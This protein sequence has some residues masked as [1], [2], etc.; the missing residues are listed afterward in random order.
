[1]ILVSGKVCFRQ[2]DLERVRPAMAAMVNASLGEDGCIDYAYSI[3]VLDPTVMRI[4]ERW[5]DRAALAAHF[6]TPHMAQ[7][8]AVLAELDISD[9]ELF[10]M[11]GD[12]LE[13]G[14]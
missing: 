8:L 14:V 7:W 1:M 6:Q 12:Q 4:I 5:R 2:T 10:M 11:D 9:R 13:F 3:D